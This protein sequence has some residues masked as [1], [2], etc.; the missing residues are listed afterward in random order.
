VEENRRM[1]K[2]APIEGKSFSHGLVSIDSIDALPMV[3]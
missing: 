2:K 3:P 1:S